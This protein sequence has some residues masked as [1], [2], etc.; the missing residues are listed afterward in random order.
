MAG[1][2]LVKIELTNC[3]FGV[4]KVEK[5]AY[6]HFLDSD[7]PILI[8]IPFGQDNIPGLIEA[9]IKANALTETQKR[10]LAPL[11]NG[12]LFLPGED[13]KEGPQG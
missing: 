12:G 5:G 1:G 4:Q 11:F 9:I 10:E 8:Q 2:S 7:S 3:T 6:F 13:F